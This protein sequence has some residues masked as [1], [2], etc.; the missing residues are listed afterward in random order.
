MSSWQTFSDRQLRR[1][2]CYISADESCVLLWVLGYLFQEQVT[3]FHRRDSQ[4]QSVISS[5]L[6]V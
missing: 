5:G 2:E 3:W 1:H 6:E 4:G